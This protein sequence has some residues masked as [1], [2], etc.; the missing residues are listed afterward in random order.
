M[1]RLSY[2]LLALIGV[3]TVA[4]VVAQEPIDQGVYWKGK[5]DVSAMAGKPIRLRINLKRA[6][7]YAFQFRAE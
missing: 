4:S 1:R 6:K 3:V 7:L 5:S 2:L